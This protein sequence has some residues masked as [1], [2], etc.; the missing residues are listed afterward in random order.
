MR[1]VHNTLIMPQTLRSIVGEGSE[2]TCGSLRWSIRALLLGIA[3]GGSCLYGASLSWTLP[4]WQAGNSAM[5]M[6]LSAGLAWII[7]IP[8]LALVAGRALLCCLD[9]GLLT[10]AVGE[11]VLVVGAGVN[12]LVPSATLAPVVVNS[13]IV[14]LANITMVAFLAVKLRRVRVPVKRTVL[15]WCVVLNGSGAIAFAA[16]HRLL[17]L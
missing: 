8:V 15:A 10:M 12:I 13:S 4:N 2:S 17:F 11:V 5:W 1:V 7:F 9:A 14:T 16:F 3:I 6:A